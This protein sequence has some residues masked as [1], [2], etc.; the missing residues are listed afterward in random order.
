[1][2]DYEKIIV[3]RSAELVQC[4]ICET[5]MG[6]V[7]DDGNELAA[8]TNHLLGHGATLLHVGQETATTVDGEPWQHTVAVL[9]LSA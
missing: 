9:G 6:S 8:Q 1:M 3:V 7:N 5:L 4:P 2:A